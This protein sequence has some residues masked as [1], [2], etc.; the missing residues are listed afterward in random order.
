MARRPGEIDD[1]SSA[2]TVPLEIEGR[3]I[4]LSIAGVTLPDGI[5]Y[6]FRDVTRERRLE[7][8]RAQ[9]VAT[10]SHELR[11]PLASLARRRHDAARAGARADRPDPA[12]PARHDRRPVE[13]ARRPGGGDPAH[14]PARQRL[15]PRRHRALRCRGARVVGGR[16]GTPPGGRR[17]HDRRVDSRCA[18]QGGGRPRAHAPGA[19]QSRRQRDQVL[20]ARRAHA[21]SE[22]RPATAT[23]ASPSATRAWASRWASRSGSSRS[24]IASIRTIGAASGEAASASTSAGSSCAR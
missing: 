20:A 10:I 24:S 3:E 14:R 11:T 15:P 7:E 21:S 13:A 22:S 4:W 6:A 18:A 23:R 19:D 12:R 17:H 9:F 2:E 5:V 16:G 8:L 1:E